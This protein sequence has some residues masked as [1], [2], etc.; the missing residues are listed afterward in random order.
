[1]KKILTLSLFLYVVSVATGT[2]VSI[3]KTQWYIN[4]QITYPGTPAEGLLMN[5]RMVNSTF[6]DRKRNDFNSDENTSRFISK[7]SEYNA[8]GVR[9]FT[10]NLQGGFP[11]Y[12]GAVNSAFAPN[13]TLRPN[14]MSRIKRVIDVCDTQGIIVILGLFYQRQDQVLRDKEAVKRGVV[15]AVHWIKDNDLTNVVIEI[16]NEYNHSG[17]DHNVIKTAE[18]EVELI[19]LAKKTAPDLL[20]S[21]SGLGHGRMDDLIAN[22]ADFI[23]IHFNGTKVEDIPKRINALKEYNKPIVCNEDDKIGEEA[24][25]ALKASVENGCSWGFMYNKLNQYEPF[26]FHGYR[27]DP[28]VY[29]TFKGL[30]GK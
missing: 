27:D 23:L 11:G 1:M 26:E 24:A 10:F 6:E 21:T 30:T 29:D 8:Y 15:N 12:E 25:L 4:G 14:Y 2:T 5:V 16:A 20:V 22:E 18:G 7:I 9:A 17:F 13:G 28:E 3:N 19:R